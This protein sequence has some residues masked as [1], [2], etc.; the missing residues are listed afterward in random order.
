[1]STSVR[2]GRWN[3]AISRTPRP[4]GTAVSPMLSS[5]SGRAASTRSRSSRTP[6]R[7]TGDRSRRPGAAQVVASG[8][9]RCQASRKV[10][11]AML[12]G[13]PAQRCRHGVIDQ[14]VQPSGDHGSGLRVGPS[15]KQRGS[16]AMDASER[17]LKGRNSAER[18]PGNAGTP[19]PVSPRRPA[20]SGPGSLPTITQRSP[21]RPR[22]EPPRR[23]CHNRA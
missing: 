19:T 18:A 9:A 2:V 15:R 20:R 6:L 21:R 23:G 3:N 12:R 5:H 4:P 10:Q 11:C 1:M 16:G 22:V 14:A 8:Q 17:P 7:R 13:Q